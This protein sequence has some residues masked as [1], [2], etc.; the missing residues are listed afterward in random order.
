MLVCEDFKL[1][2]GRLPSTGVPWHG[3]WLLHQ[4]RMLVLL[5]G[6]LLLRLGML[7]LPLLSWLCVLLL[8]LRTQ[9]LL[10]GH[11]RVLLLGRLL[12]LS[13]MRTLW[14]GPAVSQ[15]N[16]VLVGDEV[17]CRRWCCR[18]CRCCCCSDAGRCCCSGGGCCC[19]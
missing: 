19:R 14:E 5:R 4:R 3:W 18:G 1:L 15:R 13:C 12:R 10:L 11:R 2:L 6:L 17:A 8:R 7:L 16:E 9:L